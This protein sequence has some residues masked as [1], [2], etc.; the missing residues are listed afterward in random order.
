[1][2]KSTNNNSLFISESNQNKNSLLLPTEKEFK[3]MAWK[4]KE[5]K[6]I[7]LATA[8]NEL[9]EKYG[10][11]CFNSI[12]PILTQTKLIS[13][14]LPLSI[15]NSL[16]NNEIGNETCYL[17]DEKPN[18]INKLGNGNYLVNDV[19]LI[20]NNQYI[21]IPNNPKKLKHR[22]RKCTLISIENDF[23]PETAEVKFLDTK[24]IGIVDLIDIKNIN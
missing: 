15:K 11:K 14:N 9:S 7:K 2:K 22:N 23:L 24:R 1:M 17:I 8:L 3:E 13:T 12:K 21:I 16:S 19:E 20:L 10:Y 5:K 18:F 6:G 4:L